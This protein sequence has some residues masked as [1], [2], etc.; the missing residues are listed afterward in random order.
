[1]EREPLRDRHDRA[2]A[3]S[4]IVAG[5]RSRRSSARPRPRATASSRSPGAD[6]SRGSFP[7]GSRRAS[8]STCATDGLV[9]ELRVVVEHGL[10]LAEVADD[11]ALARPVRARAHGRAPDRVARGAHRRRA[12]T[13]G[14]RGRPASRAERAPEPRGA[15]P[16]DRRPERL[17]GP[18]RRH[19]HE[20]RAHAALDRRGAR[21]V[22]R[23]GQRGG[24]EGRHA[25]G[26]HGRAR[27]LGRHLLPDRPRLRRGARRARGRELAASAAAHSAARATPPTGR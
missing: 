8:T 21:R 23:G 19:G 25:R 14:A 4:P 10:K 22:D 7:G 27:E 13:D 6:G 9:V 26:A 2:R 11:G 1:M 16:P 12:G 3:R 20:P 5:T 24:R 18:R 15:P 17:P